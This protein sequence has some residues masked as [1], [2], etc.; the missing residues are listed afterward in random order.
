IQRR[1]QFGATAGTTYRIAV[2][3][4][5]GSSGSITLHITGPNGVSLSS[6]TNG[7]VATFGDPIPFVANI[8]TNFPGPPATR[9]DFYRATSRFASIS[10]APF[11]TFNTNSPVGTNSYYIVAFN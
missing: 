6:P 1:V 4:F 2:D 11:A 3:G 10:N 8:S 9:V 5:G 7:A